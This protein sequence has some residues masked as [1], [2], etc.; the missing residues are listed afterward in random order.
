M[1]LQVLKAVVEKK[2]TRSTARSNCTPTAYLFGAN[3]DGNLRRT[4]A[5]L[6][7]IAGERARNV[8]VFFQK[9]YILPRTSSVPSR[10]QTGPGCAK[11]AQQFDR[12]GRLP[13]PSCSNV[14][15]THNGNGET[16]ST[17]LFGSSIHRAASPPKEREQP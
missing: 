16:G 15:D 1:Q 3:A 8:L 11:L 9:Q 13:R 10:Q 12:H 5:K 2:D 14:S 4:H 6:N 7:F 17:S